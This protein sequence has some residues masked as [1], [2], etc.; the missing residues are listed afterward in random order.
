MIESNYI[1]HS[2]FFQFLILPENIFLHL[3]SYDLLSFE[4]N[5]ENKEK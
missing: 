4:I 2:M 3:D 1:P 5:L